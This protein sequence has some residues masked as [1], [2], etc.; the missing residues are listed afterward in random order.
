MP[1]ERI[2]KTECVT[3]GHE[4]C[5]KILVKNPNGTWRVKEIHHQVYGREIIERERY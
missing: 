4:R 1:Q 2:V 5:Y 3:M